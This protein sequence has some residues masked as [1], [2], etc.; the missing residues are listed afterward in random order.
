M[1][2]LSEDLECRNN[3]EHIAVEISS[4]VG[5]EKAILIFVR[6]Q[7]IPKR[8]DA[9]E[10]VDVFV[11][12]TAVSDV[13]EC[14]ELPIIEHYVRQA[15]VAVDQSVVLERGAVFLYHSHRLL[16]GSVAK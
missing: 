16:C 4:A 7:I 1:F 8:P 13:D 12:H 2:N 10:K 3:A 5:I 14:G 15:V 11:P 9:P 6:F